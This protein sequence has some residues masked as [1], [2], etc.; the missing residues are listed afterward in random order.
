MVWWNRLLWPYSQNK[1]PNSKKRIKIRA[2]VSCLP[3]LKKVSL[4]SAA[5]FHRR[6]T[7]SEGYAPWEEK[8]ISP[9]QPGRTRRLQHSTLVAQSMGF[10]SCFIFSIRALIWSF[11]LSVTL[12][13]VI[14]NC[15]QVVSLPVTFYFVWKHTL[16]F[17]RSCSTRW[18]SLFKSASFCSFC[19]VSSVPSIR[20]C[21]CTDSYDSYRLCY[22]NP[23]WCPNIHD[24][25]RKALHISLRPPFL[26]RMASPSRLILEH[27]DAVRIDG[28]LSVAL[29]LA[30]SPLGCGDSSLHEN[31]I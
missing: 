26:V 16:P 21:S 7:L 9:A 25:E 13:I 31:E 19:R 20:R 10:P 14:K 15:G 28:D 6:R 27:S 29:A 8:W 1:S 12:S 3:I 23:R 22:L 11:F 2:V 24:R 30:V 5:L 4:V 17:L 18:Y